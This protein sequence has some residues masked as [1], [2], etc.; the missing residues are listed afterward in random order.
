MAGRLRWLIQPPSIPDQVSICLDDPPLS[1][2]STDVIVF[3]IRA[4]TQ[5]LV[6]GGAGLTAQDVGKRQHHTPEAGAHLTRFAMAVL[7]EAQK[8]A[9]RLARANSSRPGLELLNQPFC[10]PPSKAQ[11]ASPIARLP[12]G[13]SPP[14]WP[15]STSSQLGRRK[16]RPKRFRRHSS[17][18]CS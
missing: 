15:C 11:K 5:R 14:T 18:V 10:S 8:V 4:Q 9:G 13:R 12:S 3:Y 1:R 16:R 17:L 2:G 7:A 6:L